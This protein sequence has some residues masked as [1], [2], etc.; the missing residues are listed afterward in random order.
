MRV[1]SASLVFVRESDVRPSVRGPHV[2]CVRDCQQGNRRKNRAEKYRAVRNCDWVVDSD[3]RDGIASRGRT[4]L[5]DLVAQRMAKGLW[6]CRVRT[7]IRL[8]AFLA[9]DFL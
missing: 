8:S 3:P 2:E 4:V 9:I 1:Y 6:L 7:S 5:R